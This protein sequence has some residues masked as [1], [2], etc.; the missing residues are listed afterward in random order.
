MSL[1]G[2]INAEKIQRAAFEL[3][4]H[5][6][7]EISSSK[8]AETTSLSLGTICPLPSKTT[9]LKIRDHMRL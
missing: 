8:V 6:D 4:F 7:S 1:Y 9:D 5:E 2:I 3:G